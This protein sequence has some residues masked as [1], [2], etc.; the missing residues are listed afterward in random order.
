[1]DR[2]DVDAL[3]RGAAAVGLHLDA[4]AVSLLTRFLDGLAEWNSR[5]RLTGERSFPALVKHTVD[6]LAVVQSLPAR[7]LVVDI[8][9]GGGFPGIVLAVVRP[10][11]DFVLLDARRRAVSFLRETA[12][13]LPLPNVRALHR[14]AEDALDELGQRAAAVVSRA[15]RLDEYLALAAPLVED[16]GVI[17]AMQM[18][19]R[20]VMAEAA[21][22]RVDL[23]LVEE[24]AYTLPGAGRRALL[25]FRRR[26]P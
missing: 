11:L 17:L 16:D 26:R 3:E 21:A 22:T 13:R 20:S 14:R 7:G 15:V 23:A 8:G 19:G 10:D 9:S 12:R 24:R 25:V 5:I 18:P 4:P 2:A 1:V 6:S